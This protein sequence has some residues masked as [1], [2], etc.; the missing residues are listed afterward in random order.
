MAQPKKVAYFL[1][2]ILWMG[3]IYF[4]SSFH[5]I[6][7]TE[8]GWANF[9]TRKSAHFGE[10]AILCLLYFR[11]FRKSTKLSRAK[12]GIFSFILTLA[13]AYTDE[14]HQTFV[15]GRT[16]RSFDIGVDSLGAFAGLIFSWKLVNLLPKRVRKE[17]SL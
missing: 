5:K 4:L 16:G 6:Q 9:V 15:P 7:M 2:P 12:A 13:Y 3:L 11:A 1:P 10:Y 17:L 14:Y 8:V